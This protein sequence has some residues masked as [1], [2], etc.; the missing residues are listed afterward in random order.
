MLTP[1]SWRNPA[2]EL[3]EDNQIVWIMLAPHKDRGGLVASAPSIEI[4]CGWAYRSGNGLCRVENMDELGLGSLGWYL[5]ELP[6]DFRYDEAPAI[7]W[8][9]VDEMGYPDWVKQ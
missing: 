9:P 1:M 5:G 6:D 2:N 8:L 7:A 4:V 3:P